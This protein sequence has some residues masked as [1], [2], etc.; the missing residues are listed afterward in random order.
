MPTFQSSG[1]FHILDEQGCSDAPD[2]NEAGLERVSAFQ[3]QDSQV[4]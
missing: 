1:G 3:I 4:G 2:F